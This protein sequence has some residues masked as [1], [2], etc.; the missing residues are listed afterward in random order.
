MSQTHFQC[1]APA[2]SLEAAGQ[3]HHTIVM[4]AP[5]QGLLTLQEKSLLGVWAAE[6]QPGEKSK[7]VDGGH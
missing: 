5:L 1:V 2:T 6:F 3:L 7:G 4:A